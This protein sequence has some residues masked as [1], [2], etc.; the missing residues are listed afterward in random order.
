MRAASAAMTS[1]L[2]SYA[3]TD[4]DT[5]GLAVEKALPTDWLDEQL[6]DAGIRGLEPGHLS[7]RLSRTGTDVVVRGRVD[8]KLGLSC[9]RC[10]EPAVAE[11]HGELSLLL[12]AVTPPPPVKAAT[13]KGPAKADEPKPGTRARRSRGEA[14]V[15]APA[16]SK[17][18]KEAEYEFTAEEADL[19]SYD[20]DTVILDEFV[21]EAILL[22][23]PNFPLCSDA[24]AGI[25]R[26]PSVE[27]QSQ[28]TID[29]RLL[30]LAAIRSKLASPNGKKSA[31]E[32]PTTKQSSRKP[33]KE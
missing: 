6:G 10:L 32:A 14:E 30:P 11:V 1:P 15:A 3:A 23:V 8:A 2:I 21:R 5:V 9:A 12:K 24:C 19:D 26:A 29:P 16:P 18:K 17:P 13:Q 28:E 7:A 33:N 31:S 20:G 22:E 4:L 27:G 25:P